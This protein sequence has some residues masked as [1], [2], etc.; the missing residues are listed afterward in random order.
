MLVYILYIYIYETNLNT[1]L[2]LLATNIYTFPYRPR[3]WLKINTFFPNS[4]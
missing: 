2:L 3:I 4:L 1:V